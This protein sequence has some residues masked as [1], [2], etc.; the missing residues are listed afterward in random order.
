MMMFID[1]PDATA[2]CVHCGVNCTPE[3]CKK[4]DLSGNAICP[5]DP[6]PDPS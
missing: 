5:I 4:P 1:A 3:V 6:E 2:V